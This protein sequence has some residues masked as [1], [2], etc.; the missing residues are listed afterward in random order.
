[1]GFSPFSVESTEKPDEEP[2]AKSYKI[3]DQLAPQILQ[4]QGTG[5]IEGVLLDTQVRKQDMKLGKYVLSVTHYTS[6]G[7][8]PEAKKAEFPSAGD[9]II[10]TGEDEFIIAGTGIVVTFATND[11]VDPLVGILGSDEGEYINGKWVAGRR[12]NG[13]QDHQGRHVR[14]SY[15]EWGIQQVKLYRYK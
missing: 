8:V 6:L 5:K 15:G 9:I 1:M 3:L 4:Y 2:I 7:W 11:K 13:D 12:M 14:I 10:Q